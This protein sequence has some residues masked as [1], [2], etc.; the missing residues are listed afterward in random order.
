MESDIETD[1]RFFYNASLDKYAAPPNGMSYNQ[2]LISNKHRILRINH[3]ASVLMPG[4]L[5][6]QPTAGLQP[7]PTGQPAQQLAQPAQ[8]PTQPAVQL[9]P[10]PLPTQALTPQPSS[11]VAAAAANSHET[12]RSRLQYGP[13]HISFAHSLLPDLED[14]ETHSSRPSVQGTAARLESLRTSLRTARLTNNHKVI[15]DVAKEMKIAFD[16]DMIS[17]LFASNQWNVKKAG[18]LNLALH[19]IISVTDK[20]VEVLPEAVIDQT[21]KVTD[22][23][24]ENDYNA[25]ENNTKE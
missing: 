17:E 2:F 10:V 8:Q 20:R 1:I 16:T 3:T 12:P 24:V 23:F 4:T 9:A 13:P 18:M 25:E 15:R 7:L 19:G 14:L 11:S 5:G 6:S 22:E 21:E